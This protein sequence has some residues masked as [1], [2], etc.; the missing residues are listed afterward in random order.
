MAL[1]GLDLFDVLEAK[2][3]ETWK[4]FASGKSKYICPALNISQTQIRILLERNLDP[5]HW[6]DGDRAPIVG[7]RLALL[8][9]DRSGIVHA[10]EEAKL[11]ARFVGSC[12]FM[13]LRIRH[14]E[15]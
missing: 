14:K 9:Q 5:D 15:L 10:L 11:T 8:P 6:A 2:K 7:R 4:V 12:Y 13:A 1:I 3:V